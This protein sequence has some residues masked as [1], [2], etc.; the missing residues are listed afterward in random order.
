MTKKQDSVAISRRQ[1]LKNLGVAGGGAAVYEAASA[2]GMFGT[3]RAASWR[4]PQGIGAGKSVV[5]LGAG[6]GGLAT[7]YELLKA[8]S[9]FTCTVLE[10]NPKV[11]GRC[12]TL[13]RG[14]V[15]Q[16]EGSPPQICDFVSEPGELYPPYLNAGPGRIPSA[17]TRVLDYCKDLGVSLEVYIMESRSNLAYG[18]TSEVNRHVASDARGWIAEYL[19]AMV[20]R[21][22]I[23]PTQQLD[24]QSLL[25]KFGDL[26]EHGRYA[27]CTKGTCRYTNFPARPPR[28]GYEVLPGIDV[29]KSVTPFTLDEVLATKFWE[30][31]FYQPEDFLWQPTLFQPVGGMDRIVM[32][33]Q[34]AVRSRGGVIGLNSV[35]DRISKQ[36]GRFRIDF[37]KDGTP[38]HLLADYC[39]SN[40]PIPLLDGRLE[41]GVVDPS[42]QE[43]LDAVFATPSFLAPTCKVGWQARR[44]LWQQ[45]AS[46]ERVVPIFGGISWTSHPM[47]QLWYPS[48]LFF[49]ELGVLTGTY[50]FATNAT[51]WGLESPR[52][53][54]NEAR[55][56]A[57]QLAGNA[58]ADG[59]G[60]GITIAW[61]NMPFQKGGWA[62]W[63]TVDDGL[64]HYNKLL[65]GSNGF[66]I[67]GDQLSALPGWQ[68][69]AVAS[70]VQVTE[71]ITNKRFQA[72]TVMA[73][74]DSRILVEGVLPQPRPSVD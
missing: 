28:A 7:A 52:W 58:F 59:L 26:D 29:G 34:Q 25:I 13:R 23:D 8:N 74:P 60:R 39:V 61:Q 14:D 22:P 70:A 66:H 16:E 40:I 54:L 62:Q 31:S 20:D 33:L 12:L 1:L 42:Y 67:C 43:A 63:Q 55:A 37:T 73:V 15:L 9:G 48:D 53:R 49:A 6:I 50:N 56:G 5:I 24:M 32:A 36:D 68:E 45:P 69:G 71:A 65:E 35:V 41:A 51:R 38:E 46:P 44:A 64:G 17:H 4:I 18:A 10:A 2:L 19:F 11:G 30:T 27:D 47:T 21:L 57:R 72:P 3:A